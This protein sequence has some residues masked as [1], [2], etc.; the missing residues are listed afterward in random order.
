VFSGFATL[1]FSGSFSINGAMKENISKDMI[2]KRAG[3]KSFDEKYGWKGILSK[4]GL[5]PTGLLEP[6]M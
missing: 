1:K 4:F 6:V 2:N 3:S 5:V